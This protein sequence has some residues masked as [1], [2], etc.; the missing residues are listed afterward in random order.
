MKH[1]I[2]TAIASMALIAVAATP[3][4]AQDITLKLNGNV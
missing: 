4:F 3:A 1:K 2:K